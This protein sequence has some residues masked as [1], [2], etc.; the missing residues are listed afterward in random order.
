MVRGRS[1]GNRHLPK[2]DIRRVDATQV[3][4]AAKN[5]SDGARRGFRLC[6]RLCSGEKR[7][8]TFADA[9]ESDQGD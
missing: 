4:I 3:R 5:S 1:A 7:N 2:V 9:N 6:R 8:R